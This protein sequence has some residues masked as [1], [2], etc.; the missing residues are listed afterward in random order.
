MVSGGTI[1]GMMSVYE[2]VLDLKFTQVDPPYAWAPGVQMFVAQ[3]AKSQAV[4]GA[5]YLD[6]FPREGKFNHSACFP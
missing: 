6:M 1:E 2:R 5:F 4:M 3:D